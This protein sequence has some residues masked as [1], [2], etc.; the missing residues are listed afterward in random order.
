[1]NIVYFHKN[2]KSF[3]LSLERKVSAKINSAIYLLSIKGYDLS[4]PYSKKIEKNLFELRI[5]GLQNIRI[6]YTFYNNQ[7]VL[8]HIINKQSQR[9]ELNDLSTARK[10]LSVLHS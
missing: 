5:S 6:F 9:L 8:L 2:I 4:M 7:I 10:R 3:I 1:M